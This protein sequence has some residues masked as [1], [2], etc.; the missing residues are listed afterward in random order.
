MRLARVDPV[1]GTLTR[2][3]LDDAFSE[4]PTTHAGQSAGPVSVLV[5]DTNSVDGP[6]AEIVQA[7]SSADVR[8]LDANPGFG[9]G[10]NEV[11]HVVELLDQS[12][13]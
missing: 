12:L 5:V 3:G 11:L 6:T 1:S 9:G 10:A 8:R 13:A 4:S 7:L 2:D